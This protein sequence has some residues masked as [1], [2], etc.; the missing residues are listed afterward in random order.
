MGSCLKGKTEVP[1]GKARF[2]CK[3]CGGMTDDKSHLCK[4]QKL[5]KKQKK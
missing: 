1:K 3:K 2:Q 4:P 5:K